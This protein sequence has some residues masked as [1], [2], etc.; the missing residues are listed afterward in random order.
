MGLKSLRNAFHLDDRV[1]TFTAAPAETA[2]L[3]A[4]KIPPPWLDNQI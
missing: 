1:L 3:G 4:P 2:H